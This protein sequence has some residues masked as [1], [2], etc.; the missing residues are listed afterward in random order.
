MCGP[1]WQALTSLSVCFNMYDFG[2]DAT[3]L[4]DAITD[5]WENNPAVKDV[6]PVQK[7]LA[8]AAPQRLA[9]IISG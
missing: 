9:F 8:R 5:F 4:S 6:Q 3:G 2:L 1:M 7:W